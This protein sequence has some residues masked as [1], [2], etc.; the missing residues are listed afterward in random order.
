MVTNNEVKEALNNSVPNQV[1]SSNASID[2]AMVLA[3]AAL[4]KEINNV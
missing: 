2:E 3:H 1:E 4:S